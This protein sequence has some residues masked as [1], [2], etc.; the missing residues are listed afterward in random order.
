MGFKRFP[1]RGFINPEG[2]LSVIV[3]PSVLDSSQDLGWLHSLL[4]FPDAEQC[5]MSYLDSL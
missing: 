2:F 1:K 5:D 4:D 3:C